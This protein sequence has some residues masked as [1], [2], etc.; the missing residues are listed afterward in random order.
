VP[1]LVASFHRLL[2]DSSKSDPQCWAKGAIA[3]ALAELDVQEPDAFIAGM[4]TFQPGF[5]DDAATALRG[6]CAL[7]SFTTYSPII[8]L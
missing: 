6:A 7:A 8:R 5:T 2:V 3:K 4:R 1:D